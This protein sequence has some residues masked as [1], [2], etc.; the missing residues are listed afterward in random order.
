M[1]V[2]SEGKYSPTKQGQILIDKECFSVAFPL[3]YF[4]TFRKELK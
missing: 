2:N 1:K 3:P 4:D